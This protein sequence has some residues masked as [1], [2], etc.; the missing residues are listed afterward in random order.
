MAVRLDWSAMVVVVVGTDVAALAVAESGRLTRGHPATDRCPGR[1]CVDDIS[2]NIRGGFFIRSHGGRRGVAIPIGNQTRLPPQLRHL[3]GRSNGPASTAADIS[4]LR[5][6]GADTWRWNWFPTFNG[7]FVG[8]YFS[9]SH[10]IS[11]GGRRRRG[12]CTDGPRCC[13]LMTDSA[14]TLL[15][16]TQHG[17]VRTG[18]RSK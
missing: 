2:V 4:P 10:T 18:R 13:A 11:L 14:A 3:V 6:R 8:R 5:R 16:Q 17:Q 12:S 1:R 7:R 9:H 15:G